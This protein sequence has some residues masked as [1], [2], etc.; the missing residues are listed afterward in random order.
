MK[1][2]ILAAGMG[3]RLNALIPKPLVSLENEKTIL[4]F[5]VEKL[6]KK[7]G[8]NNIIVVVGYKKELIMEK[9]P[10]LIYIYNNEFATTNT[11]KSL[12][13]ALLKVED[14]T[15]WMNG[16]VFFD[17]EALDLLINSKHSGCLV[18]NE[19]CGEEE[20]KY[21]LN[22]EGSIHELSK[23]VKDGHGEAL[24]INIIKKHDLDEF[25]KE[26]NNVG[27][28]D[29]FE[30]AL[31]NLTIKNKLV[32]KP[33]NKKQLFCKEIDFEEDLIQVREHMKL[34]KK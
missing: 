3:T 8:M 29:Y 13:R 12:Y 22:K 23:Q 11:A 20:I 19:K 9:F 34:C 24:G 26:L 31:E 14:D 27:Q 33:I 30:K 1:G 15:I 17:I 7:I 28:K 32:L 4:D 25:R 10:D 16:D 18:D 2:V 21:N 5:Q 6:A